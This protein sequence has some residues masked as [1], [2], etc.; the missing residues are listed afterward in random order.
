MTNN[1][2][3]IAP[4]APMHVAR[5]GA[6]PVFFVL[7]NLAIALFLV[8][9]VMVIASN[10]SAIPVPAFIGLFTLLTV[11]MLFLA[12]RDVAARRMPWARTWGYWGCVFYGIG[13][14]AAAHRLGLLSFV[15]D[16]IL[17]WLLGFACSALWLR[18]RINFVLS[19]VLLTLWLACSFLYGQSYLPG[20]AVFALLGWA[21][22][23][24]QPGAAPLL[25]QALNGLLLVALYGYTAIQPQHYPLQFP[26]AIVLPL[27]A[28]LA[29]LW[30][31]ASARQARRDVQVLGRVVAGLAM[32]LLLLLSFDPLWQAWRSV[33]IGPPS[34]V[35]LALAGLIGLAGLGLL[36]RRALPAPAAL[37]YLV[38]CAA[39][40]LLELARWWPDSLLAQQGSALAAALA[41]ALALW[42]MRRA[43][44]EGRAADLLT[45]SLLL[46]LA[47]GA[48]VL[49]RDLPYFWGVL[50]L[51]LL[52][53]VL[54]LA[55]TLWRNPRPKPVALA[56]APL[57]P[58]A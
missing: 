42:R 19:E 37:L 29:L 54:L 17:L 27:L 22:R 44:A 45:G 12:L 36:K 47:V 58:V 46:V 1:T 6:E 23:G 7:L 2:I 49:S 18:H 30:A 16:L 32:A 43:V 51:W 50:A 38:W 31:A 9:A 55:L 13:T 56:A 34:G 39:A 4:A 20:L 33:W 5:S 53:G 35:A 48:A 24:P 15:P 52:A 40:V 57:V 3:Q 25:L 21:L 11:L 26:P 41:G 14:I 10:L 8:G 28:S